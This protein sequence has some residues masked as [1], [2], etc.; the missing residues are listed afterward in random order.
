MIGNM[1]SLF[2]K[3]ISEIRKR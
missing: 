3:Q 1:V 2:E